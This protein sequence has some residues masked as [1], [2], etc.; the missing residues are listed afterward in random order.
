MPA[1]TMT[2]AYLRPKD[3]AAYMSVSLSRFYEILAEKRL[4]AREVGG[5]R[6]V[7]V[8]EIEALIDGCPPAEIKSRRKTNQPT[9]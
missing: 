2:P 1:A 7:K 3:A 5:I 9:P 6:L 8:A 4:V